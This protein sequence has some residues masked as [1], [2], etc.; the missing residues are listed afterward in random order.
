MYASLQSNVFTRCH[1]IVFFYL[2]VNEATIE[3]MEEKGKKLSGYL[4]ELLKSVLAEKVTI[5][6]PI[7]ISS[8][9]CQ[10]SFTLHH[11]PTVEV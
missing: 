11:V 10:V 4:I 2:V 6:S 1:N 5:I 9:C 3:A 7:A 8:R